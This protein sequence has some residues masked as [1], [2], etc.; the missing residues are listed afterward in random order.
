MKNI[1]SVL[2]EK[3]PLKKRFV[4]AS[5]L[6]LNNAL[7]LVFEGNYGGEHWLATFAVMALE[8]QE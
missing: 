5:N 4:E 8:N 6:L 7:P 2:T 1:A 3:H